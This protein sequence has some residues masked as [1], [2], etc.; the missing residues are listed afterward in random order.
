MIKKYTDKKTKLYDILSKFLLTGKD[1]LLEYLIEYDDEAYIKNLTINYILNNRNIVYYYDKY[2]EI[3]YKKYDFSDFMKTMSYIIRNNINN[4]NQFL[5]LK[6]NRSKFNTFYADIKKCGID[7]LDDID[8]LFRLHINGILSKHTIDQNIIVESE[9]IE[10]V[11][12][13]IESDSLSVPETSI[14]SQNILSE[15]DAALRDKISEF[16]INSPGCKKC[17]QYNNQALPMISNIDSID[18]PYTVKLVFDHPPNNKDE[19]TFI[20]HFLRKLR[21]RSIKFI[22]VFLYSCSN[23]TKEPTDKSAIKSCSEIREKLNLL[24][25]EKL[26]ILFGTNC[27]SKFGIK[28][29]IIQTSGKLHFGKY[30]VIESPYDA[31]E[32]EKKYERYQKNVDKLIEHIDEDVGKY[33]INH[34]EKPKPIIE[35]SVKSKMIDTPSKDLSLFNIQYMEEEILYIFI[36]KNGE[37]FYMKKPVEHEVFIKLGKMMNNGFITSDKMDFKLKVNKKQKEELCKMLNNKIPKYLKI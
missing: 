4:K 15:I 20:N 12:M 10:S 16:K 34:E 30:F 9:K 14:S 21:N 25:K 33:T 1:D 32:D 23:T 6:F 29:S 24:N 7:S 37:K 19:M 26:T 22:S 11:K 31:L 27:K 2:L 3:K 17:T 18:S 35:K 5:Y 8:K 28:G 13:D 36:D